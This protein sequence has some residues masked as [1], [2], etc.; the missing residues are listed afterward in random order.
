ML[1]DYIPSPPPLL[2]T[3]HPPRKVRHAGFRLIMAGLE[4]TPA[5]ESPTESICPYS[6]VSG[7]DL[8]CT[9]ALLALIHVLQ[10]ASKAGAS[11]SGEC[12]YE[13]GH[14]GFYRRRH[15]FHKPVFFHPTICS[16]FKAYSPSLL[17]R[18]QQRLVTPTL[19]PT[20]S[21]VLLRCCHSPPFRMLL[22]S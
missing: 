15:A 18:T 17:I 8:I 22:F 2:Y 9:L 5:I 21:A 11:L 20:F 19:P 14:P 12:S 3:P 4:Q 6:F 7:T 10:L 13:R 16:S 1:S